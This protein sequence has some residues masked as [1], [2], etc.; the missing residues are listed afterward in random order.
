MVRM[1]FKLILRQINN[2][3]I[4]E[5]AK[6]EERR[7]CIFQE[8]LFSLI[9]AENFRYAVPHVIG[10]V[11]KTRKFWCEVLPE[12]DEGRFREL[13]RVNWIN[14]ETILILIKNNP[15]FKGTRSCRQFPVS[16]QL[17]IVLYRLG[18]SGE[19]ATLTKVASFFGI[20]DGGT[21]DIITTRVFRAILDLR[22]QYLSWPNAAERQ[23]IVSHTFHELP[24]CI[25]YVDGTEI[26]LAEKPIE[27]HEAYFSH[28]RIYALKVQAVC[29]Y[30]LKIRHLVLGY[31]GSVHDS[32]IYNNCSLSL[33][34]S[35]YFDGAQWIADDSA[36]KLT[37]TVIVP[38]RKNANVGSNAQRNVFNSTIS[39]YRVRIEHCFGRLKDRFNS[40][41]ELRISLRNS[42]STKFACKWILVCAIL[43]NIV[44]GNK[45][46]V[47]DVFE[48]M[49]NTSD[50]E[51]EDE[52]ATA[53]DEDNYPTL[54]GEAKRRALLEIINEIDN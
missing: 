52:S 44:E 16:L 37:P 29:D 1:Q 25:G 45:E 6:L 51:E 13:V 3:S 32:R 43:H 40:L 7:N 36:Y 4:S 5:E 35:R 41:K 49:E 24:H 10:S 31:P 9:V 2:T 14:F 50:T 38:Y 26:K 21:I 54:A 47:D 8:L 15:V 27:D 39:K 28:K 17:L 12:L 34:S 48:S 23:E 42:D 53:A 18:C 46:N 22:S 11:P 19:G 33:D 20:G 30:K